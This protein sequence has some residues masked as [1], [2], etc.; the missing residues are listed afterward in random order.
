MLF[1]VFNKFPIGLKQ[2]LREEDNL[3]KWTNGP[4]PM[5]P[6]FG[7]FTV[8]D[9][10]GVLAIVQLGVLSQQCFHINTVTHPHHTLHQWVH[11]GKDVVMGKK[12]GLANCTLMI[13]L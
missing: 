2:N 12:I 11:E 9:T 8:Y 3:Y 4:S 7:G 1:F 5:C 10:M 6:L 13:V